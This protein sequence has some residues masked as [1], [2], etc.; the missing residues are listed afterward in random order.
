MTDGEADFGGAFLPGCIGLC[1]IPEQ[2]T[3]GDLDS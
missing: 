2:K 3:E 1:G